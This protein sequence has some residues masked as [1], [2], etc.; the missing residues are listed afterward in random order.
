MEKPDRSYKGGID[1]SRPNVRVQ[2]Q[3]RWFDSTVRVAVSTLDTRGLDREERE[4]E[5]ISAAVA[6]ILYL[7]EFL[8]S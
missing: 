3:V 6:G 4:E 2:S 1:R 8:Q 7:G 5:A